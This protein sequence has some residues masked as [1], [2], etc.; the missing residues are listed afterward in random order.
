MSIQVLL[1]DYTGNVRQEAKLS[2]TAEVS[3]L[4]R[5]IVGRLKMPVTDSMG[6][7]ITYHLSYQ[8][9]RLQ[10]N[11]TLT[12]AEIQP[13]GTLTIV[14]E[15]PAGPSLDE[16]INSLL[17]DRFTMLEKGA[18]TSSEQL[19]RVEKTLGDLQAALRRIQMTIGEALIGPSVGR[20]N[21][22]L[23][24][25]TPR[26]TDS[27]EL[28]SRDS[29]VSKQYSYST[30]P[31]YLEE[32][33]SNI[34]AKPSEKKPEP[35][36]MGLLSTLRLR[37]VDEPLTIRNISTIFTSLNALCTKCWLIAKDQL[38]SLVEYTQTHTDRFALEENFFIT[39][40][41]HN[42]PFNF[43][44]RINPESVANALQLAI[45]AVSLTGLRK[46]EQELVLQTK[47]LDIKLKEQEA[48]SEEDNN[49]VLR[50]RELQEAELER[51]KKLIELERQQLELEKQRFELHSMRIKFALETAERMVDLLHPGADQA[52]KIMIVQTLLPDL[53]QLGTSRGLQLALPAPK[54][55]EPES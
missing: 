29:E 11:E 38:D 14:P 47:E 26:F 35:D 28:L 30:L 18:E 25:V 44:I 4:I 41:T 42:S 34:L 46:K 48:R 33:L 55:K 32:E 23:E 52:T 54:E 2:E 5:A 15:F 43:D 8:N 16:S 49:E 39:D 7:P 3:R 22:I 24:L 6:R 17:L 27:Q 1:E 9:R 36:E 21:E 31:T 40:I 53:L 20:D 50:Q 19:K 51:Q 45:D 37:I 10:E 13:G 12:S